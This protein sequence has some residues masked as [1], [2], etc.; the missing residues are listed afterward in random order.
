[1]KNPDL[2]LSVPVRSIRSAQASDW[3][4]AVLAG[5]SARAR[6][7][8]DDAE[9]VPFLLTRALPVARQ[10]LRT[11]ARGRRRAGLVCSA[12]A[13]RLRAEGI[14]PNFD[15][16]DEKLVANWFLAQWPDVRASDALE[17]PATQF[18]C[19]GLELD[20]VGLCWGNDLV[21]RD[22]RVPWV[23]RKFKGTRWQEQRAA[24]AVAFQINSYR[25]LLTRARYETVIWVPNGDAADV[26]RPP[27]EFDAV[28]SFLLACGVT[29]LPLVIDAVQTEPEQADLLL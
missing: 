18:A 5:D 10:Y 15:H 28:A 11:V 9:A 21:R 14:D 26:T 17:V 4:D 27:H 23:T 3:V 6:Q 1:V 2:H 13:R 12:A 29:Q 25:V 7:I 20:Y 24:V 16:M 22:S 8:A 19:Q